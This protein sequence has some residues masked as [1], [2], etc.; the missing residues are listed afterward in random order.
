MSDLVM[1]LTSVS[2]SFGA[3]TILNDISLI[4]NRKERLGIVGENGIGK[5]TLAQIMIGRLEPDE[6]SIIIPNPSDIGYLPQEPIIEEDMTITQFLE[7]ASG[8]LDI[9]RGRLAEIERVLEIGGLPSDVLTRTL[10]QYGALQERFMAHGGYD[11]EYRMEEVLSGLSLHHLDRHQDMRKI[12][13]GEKTRVMLAALLLK[14]PMLLVLDEPT[15]HL[16]FAAVEWLEDYIQ[17]YEGALVAI[18]HDRRFLNKIVTSIAELSPASQSLTLYKGDYDQYLAVKQKQFEKLVEAFEAQQEEIKRLERVIRV[19]TY[20]SGGGR[21]PTDKDKMAYKYSG[22][23]VEKT[24]SRE[25]QSARKR[26][27]EIQANPLRRPTGRWSI[28]PD[29]DPEQIESRKAIEF[30]RVSKSYGS[31]EVIADFSA[32]VA[33]GSKIVIVG[34]NGSG[35]T[36]LL[37]MIMGLEIP[38]S[39]TI[40]I[41]SRVRL[42]YL[43]QEQESLDP[44]SIVLEEYS[45]GLVGS[46][47]EHRAN[48]HKYGL[49]SGD[50]VDQKVD[51]LS[52]GQKRK[53]QIAKLIALRSNV[54]VLDEP[55]NHLDLESIELFEAALREFKGTV[56]ATSHERVFIEHVADIVWEFDG[57]TI[58]IR[59]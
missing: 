37:K 23:R 57:K 10:D 15:N 14:S 3:K 59:T 35:K 1:Q 47:D 20:S 55:T 42:G 9:I 6:G 22:Q 2:K 25:I 30:I 11:S 7:R 49:F 29:F 17:T 16:D 13:G 51:S 58:L 54:L 43:D 8:E 5:T 24:K 41:A 31:R 4:I 12:S 44:Q 50:Q 32:S 26:L 45:R 39:G 21:G 52:Q 56:I 33:S 46:E 18:A 28:N 53:L 36:T 19:K 40:E 27:Q 38:T 34:P 48:L